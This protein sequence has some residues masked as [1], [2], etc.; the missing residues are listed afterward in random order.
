MKKF[1]KWT[2]IVILVLIVIVVA[3]AFIMQ[4]KYKKM[5]TVKY[6]VHVPAI[7]ILTDSATLERGASIAASTCTSC[8]GGDFAGKDFFNDPKIGIIYSAN[9][10]PGGKTKDYTDTDW[11]RAIRYGV[12]PDG[13]GMF[14]MPVQEFNHMSDADL[15]SLIGYLK[16]LPAADKPQPDNYL[17]FVSQVMA[18]A[19]LF[20]ELYNA[21]LL[22]L[23][24]AS[25]RTA[26]AFGESA[27]YGKYSMRIRGCFTCHGEQ[28]NG[29]V[30]PDPVSPPGS[31][32]TPGGNIGKWSYDQFYE[33]IHTGK[34]PEGKELDI[35]FMPWDQFRLMTD[36][37]LKAIYNY[38]MSIPALGD[39]ED[40]I[41]WNK[42]NA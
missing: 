6:E 11:I 40:I 33:T 28:L 4:G 22:D 31:N 24:D 8:H 13:S 5:A 17:S 23:M 25:P 19:G 3:F 7:T 35:K 30:T 39:S 10:T 14:V 29:L 21:E 42:K 18:G 16:T 15:G 37:E 41:H 12:K 9:L 36:T 20:G 34:T 26:P 32:I 1:L 27:E 38:I 2:G